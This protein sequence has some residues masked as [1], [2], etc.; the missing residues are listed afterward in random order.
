VKPE[1]L[2]ESDTA[3]LERSRAQHAHRSTVQRF[4]KVVAALVDL[5]GAPLVAYIANVSETRAVR[6][7]ISGE[8]VPHPTTQTKLQ[9]AL[10]VARYLSEEGEDGAIEAWFQ[11]LNPSLSDNAPA[12]LIRDA[13]RT[14]LSS[15]GRQILGAANEFSNS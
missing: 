6:Q 7:W 15:I 8:R 14:Q 13:E 2:A 3:A 11:S 12:E 1:R 4:P 10:Q 5:V 9:L